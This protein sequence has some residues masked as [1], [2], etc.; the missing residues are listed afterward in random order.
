M[1]P[2]AAGD[3]EAAVTELEMS[4]KRLEENYLSRVNVA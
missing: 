1:Q 2:F 3:A 4:L